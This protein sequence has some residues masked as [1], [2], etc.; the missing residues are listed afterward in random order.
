MSIQ[1][2]SMFYFLPLLGLVALKNVDF[3][4]KVVKYGAFSILAFIAFILYEFIA[5]LV[6][7]TINF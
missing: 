3:I 1:Y 6:D 5:G 7:D 4:V 2:M